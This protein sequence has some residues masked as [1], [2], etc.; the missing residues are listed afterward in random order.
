MKRSKVF[1]ATMLL[2]GLVAG[3]AHAASLDVNGT[4]ALVGSFG[5]EVQFAGD[6][7][8][9]YV[10]DDTPANETVYRASFQM[11]PTNLNLGANDRFT[12]L[13][14]RDQDQSTGTLRLEMRRNA[15]NRMRLMGAVKKNDGTFSV[16]NNPVKWLV[17][18]NQP[19]GIMVEAVF[20]FGASG[21][22]SIKVTR[23][24][25]NGSTMNDGINNG[26]FNLDL[27]RFGAPRDV[28]AGTTGSLYLDEFES[29]RTLA[30]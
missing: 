3:G 28:D 13:F 15:T 14:G 8:V 5:L 21:G 7:Q 19:I 16:T 29:F 23:L 26:N 25:T 4:A 30:P 20:E 1:L 22:G 11:D 24:D 10:Q 6:T 2:A 27:V 12:V 17:V 9:A 18:G